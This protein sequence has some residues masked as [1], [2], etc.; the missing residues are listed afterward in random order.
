MLRPAPLSP[1]RGSDCECRTR[2]LL[3]PYSQTAASE[4][5]MET[6]KL[7][8]RLPREDVEFAKRY[9]R[10]HGITV[11][12]LIDRYFSRLRTGHWGP[13]HPEVERISGLVPE[14]VDAREFYRSHLLEKHR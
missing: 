14:D 5:A 10:E 11:T 12:A 8:V 7:T 9:A 13:I 4:K 3:L 1:I 6:T 2:V